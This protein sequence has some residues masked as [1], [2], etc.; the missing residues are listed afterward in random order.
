SGTILA[1]RLRDVDAIPA[2]DAGALSARFP[3]ARMGGSVTGMDIDVHARR[4]IVLTYRDIWLFARAPTETW[5][6]AFGRK[7]VRFPLP[8]MA[9]AEAI[10]FD[11]NGTM[12][13]VSGEGRP[14]PWLSFRFESQAND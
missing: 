5:S 4:A 12:I 14:A 10:G 1:T 6:E 11:R 13:R 3:A 2:P 9:A 8:A 7:P